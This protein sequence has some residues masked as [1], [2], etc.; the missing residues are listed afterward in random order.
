METSGEDYSVLLTLKL[1]SDR[2]GMETFQISI[3]VNN[4]WNLSLKSD[5]CGM[6]PTYLDLLP[7]SLF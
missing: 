1:K 7:F 6:K 4:N 3:P 5:R 2:C